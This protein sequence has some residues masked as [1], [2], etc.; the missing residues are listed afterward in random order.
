MPP[1]AKGKEK[2]KRID[3]KSFVELKTNIIITSQRDEMMFERYV[4]PHSC[5][6]LNA[7]VLHFARTKLLKHYVQSFLLGVPLIIVGFRTRPGV[8]SALQRFNTLEIPRLSVHSAN[9]ASINPLI[10]GICTQSPWETSLVGSP[11]LS[12]R[13]KITPLLHPFH[14]LVESGNEIV[15]KALRS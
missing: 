14:H 10:V 2:E 1:S 6:R 7:D 11:R 9:R 12:R 4:S 15:R 13:R 5:R 8:L 3:P